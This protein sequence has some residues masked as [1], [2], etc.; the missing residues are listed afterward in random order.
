MG[1]PGGNAPA[2]AA[3]GAGG[4]IFAYGV[5]H[6]VY[7]DDGSDNSDGGGDGGGDFDFG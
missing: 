4:V 7:E 5:T 2:G 1:G 6:T 3:G